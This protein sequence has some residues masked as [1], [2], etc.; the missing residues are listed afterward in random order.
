MVE[1]L[2]PAGSLDALKAAI[3]GGADAVYLGGPKFSARAY[4]AN[5]GDEDL[6]AAIR[7]CKEA[8]VKIYI[9]INTLIKETEL[10]EAYDYA[11]KVWNFG[12]DAI[13]IQDAGLIRLLSRHPAV[14]LHASTQMTVHNLA[15]ADLLKDRGI[16]RLVLAREL[17]L[18][19]IKTI[20]QSH[21]I[22]AFVHGALC[23][24]YSGKCLMSSFLGGRSGNRGRCTQSCRLPYLL[25]DS[26][27]MQ[28]AKDYLMSPK[29]LSTIDILPDL[30]GTG[31]ASLK[32]EGRMKRPEYVYEVTR[33]YRNALDGKDF[34]EKDLMQLFNRQG[35]NHFFLEGDEG[36]DMM[37]FESPKN[38]GLYLGK[39]AKGRVRLTTDLCLGDGIATPKAGFIVTKILSQGK[40]VQRADK[41]QEV[42]IYPKSY[43]EGDRLYKS[44]D[45]ALEKRIA[46]GLKEKVGQRHKADLKAVFQVGQALKLELLVGDKTYQVLGDK[47]QEAINQPLSLDRLEQS[48][49]KTG[50]TPFALDR[51]GVDY[52][53]GFLPTGAINGARRRLL[54]LAVQDLVT[55]RREKALPLPKGP[56]FQAKSRLPAKLLLLQT[57]DQ[58][59]AFL[60][61]VSPQ[62]DLVMALDVFR[63]PKDFLRPSHLQAVSQ[64]GYRFFLKAPEILLSE[65]ETILKEIRSYSRLAG[66][67]GV[68]TDNLGL[69]RDLADL[70]LIGDY[71]L[72]LFNS[73]AADLYPELS[74]G[75]FSRELTFS[76]LKGLPFRQGLYLDVY[77]RVEL[78]H[79]EYCPVGASLGGK[80]KDRAC[81]GPCHNQAFY[82]ENPSKD[83]FPVITDRFC[84]STIYEEAPLNNLDQWKEMKEAG[85]CHF[86]GDLSLETRQ[87]SEAVIRAFLQERPL[88]RPAENRGHW[89]KGVE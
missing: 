26:T 73:Q 47:V 86:R 53:P 49:R 41:G 5:F 79:S 20:S 30:V 16:T 44:S 32:I 55:E 76:D 38:T 52:E 46:Q 25:K 85:F 33:Q 15:G 18:A 13:I 72:N 57:E 36:K 69:I 17:T 12:V 31:I 51:V 77:G 54:D 28:K 70:N 22:E 7:H 29:D 45:Q 84:R 1:L 48:L 24:A 74:G 27:G 58:L 61:L 63:R 11:L 83:R 3:L 71:K 65:Y 35:F 67:A 19:E 2:S 34:A 21:E 4:A 39:V 10:A 88:I 50:Q 43:G 42:Q 56:G 8:A 66:F 80:S 14:E 23:V 37:A 75:S 60:D 59:K 89:I 68:I 6:K 64:G 9:T 78:M 82:L 40:E 62:D 87:D 81:S